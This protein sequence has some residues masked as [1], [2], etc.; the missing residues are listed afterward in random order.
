[1]RT[2]ALALLLATLWLLMSGHY[3]ALLL[4]LG[5]IAVGFVVAVSARLRIIDR[6]SV[7][8]HLVPR[9]PTYAVWLLKE[10]VVSNLAVARR[11]LSPRLRI[12]PSVIRVPGDQPDDVGRALYA[13]SITLTPGTVTVDVDD[14]SMVVHALT[15]ASRVALEAGDMGR[16]VTKVA[17]GGA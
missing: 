12:E 2:L 9:M 1:M 13:N 17:E 10:I 7:P 11:I 15:D 8:L 5:A 4:S 16:R 3:D 14:A 6:E